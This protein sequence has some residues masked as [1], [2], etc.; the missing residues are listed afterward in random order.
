M[1]SFAP[2]RRMGWLPDYPDFRDYTE[3]IEAIQDLL[4]PESAAIS[5]G[6]ATAA[7]SGGAATAATLAFPCA[8]TLNKKTRHSLPDL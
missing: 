2:K 3:D 4:H 6:A 7:I 1:M 5:G 8:R